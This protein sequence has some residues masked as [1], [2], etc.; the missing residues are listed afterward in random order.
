MKIASKEN[1]Q[2][3]SLKILTVTAII[4]LT[5]FTIPIVQVLMFKF[6]NPLFTIPM[7]WDWCEKKVTGKNYIEFSYIW[8]NINEISPNL[9]RA[10]LAAEDQRFLSHNGFD[11]IEIKKV[12]NGIKSGKKIRG[13]STITMQAARSLFLIPSRS[14]VRKAIEA[15][16]T[17]FMEIFWSK[18]RILEIYLNTVDWGLATVGAE[19]ASERYFRCSAK[20]L[21]K[22]QAAILA[23]ILPSPHTLSPT[24]PDEYLKARQKRVMR[25]MPLMPLL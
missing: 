8:K 9:R 3:P 2:R 12:L 13:A 21:T 18:K 14:I 4:V 20:N 15:Y 11:F 22:S 16:Y 7:I 1:R 6:I 25:D 5:L 23:A 17:I 10:V 24:E 19:A